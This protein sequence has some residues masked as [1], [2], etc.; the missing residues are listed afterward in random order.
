[1]FQ[2]EW[3][4]SALDELTTVWTDANSSLREAIS[5]AVYQIDQLLSSDPEEQGESRE[6]AR[7][8]LLLSP[9]GVLFRVEDNSRRVTVFHV[10]LFRKR[11]A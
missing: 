4:Q 11:S 1:M 2:V 3:L 5:S 8:I 9:L 10:W 6:E 7:R